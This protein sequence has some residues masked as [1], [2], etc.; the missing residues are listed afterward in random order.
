MKR[1]N[2]PHRG[3]SEGRSLQ[4][5]NIAIRILIISEDTKSSKLYFEDIIEEVN[6][7][8]KDCIIAAEVKGCGKGTNKLLEDA[9]ALKKD[10]ERKKEITF[11]QSW[12]VFDK[13][14]F[15]DDSFDN[16]IEKAPKDGFEVAWSNVCFELWYLLHFS[17]YH[18]P[19]GTP[20]D[21]EVALEKKVQRFIPTFKYK[22][23]SSK[24]YAIL[25]KH[26]DQIQALV[27]AE[28]LR[29]KHKKNKQEN[30]Y[31]SHTPCTHVDLLIK[32]ITDTDARRKLLLKK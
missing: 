23:G 11:D 30:K 27:R 20:K 1:D 5:R 6:S 24:M 3:F 12:L 31:S 7:S 28:K 19:G 17:D 26:G 29:K 13:D 14:N 4:T 16:T 22:K 8:N 25:S 15:T 18:N 9:L 2:H 10:I 21:Y 32:K